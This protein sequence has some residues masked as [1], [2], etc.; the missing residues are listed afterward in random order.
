[1]AT[2]GPRLSLSLHFFPFSGCLPSWLLRKSVV[3]NF[4]HSLLKLQMFSE[5]MSAHPVLNQSSRVQ[6]DV[7]R[8]L[9]H[10][11]ASRWG[12]TR[13]ENVFRDP[14]AQIRPGSR[15]KRGGAPPPQSAASGRAAAGERVAS[16]WN[17]GE[18]EISGLR[19]KTKGPCNPVFWDL[20][21][22]LYFHFA[23]FRY[24]LYFVI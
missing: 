16:V 6:R 1:M 23:N 8:F 12:W 2:T 10:V 20:Y 15:E 3:C 13:Q 14:D 7:F 22:Y 4:K 11:S 9:S 17:V 18:A 19:Y 24:A 5:E 21:F